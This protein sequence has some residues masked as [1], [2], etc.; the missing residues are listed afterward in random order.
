VVVAADFTVE[1]TDVV[2]VV[3]A[4]VELPD[5]VA[6]VPVPVVDFVVVS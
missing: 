5:V 1:V 6:V 2:A 4:A 3:P